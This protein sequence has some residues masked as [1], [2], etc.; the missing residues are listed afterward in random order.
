MLVKGFSLKLYGNPLKKEI[1][2]M[3]RTGPKQM[4]DYIKTEKIQRVSGPY[5]CTVSTLSPHIASRPRRLLTEFRSKPDA[6]TIVKRDKIH[7]QSRKTK[8][9]KVVPIEGCEK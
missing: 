9:H 3:L 4:L 8:K 1:E 6:H 5:K 2:E 7:K